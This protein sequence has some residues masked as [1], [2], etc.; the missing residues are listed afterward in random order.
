MQI[1]F[2][3]PVEKNSLML[4]GQV[5]P[6]GQIG[7][8]RISCISPSVLSPDIMWHEDFL[9]LILA[10]ELSMNLTEEFILQISSKFQ[11]STPSK[12]VARSRWN[13]AST[14]ERGVF[15]GYALISGRRKV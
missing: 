15:Q 4:M 1:R 12:R 3:I 10:I 11:Q 7:I 9:Y 2:L 13:I 5:A 6:L 8:L 14:K